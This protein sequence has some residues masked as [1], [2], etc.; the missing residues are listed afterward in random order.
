[1]LSDS[2]K[3]SE[4]KKEIEYWNQYYKVY[5]KCI[6]TY[7]KKSMSQYEFEKLI[8][9]N[10]GE[11]FIIEMIEDLKEKNIINDDRYKKLYIS[12]MEDNI[13]YS[14]YRIEVYLRD[15]NIIINDLEIE[16][17]REIDLEKANQVVSK[18]VAKTSN[19]SKYE[20]I[21]TCKIKLQSY[22]Y[23]NSTIEEALKNFEYDESTVIRKQF[24]KLLKRYDCDTVIKKLYAKGYNYDAL[25]EL[26]EEYDG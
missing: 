1:M 11:E 16:K 8:L 20:M 26:K 5:N 4:I 10:D 25:K 18:M 15:M 7:S 12:S 19:K 9:K 22:M 21:N 3:C 17:L 13:K 14:S 2:V 6:N 23:K 24:E